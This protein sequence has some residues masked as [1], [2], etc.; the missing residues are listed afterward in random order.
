MKRIMAAAACILMGMLG[1]YLMNSNVP[2]RAWAGI[3][4][5]LP[6]LWQNNTTADATQV[7]QNFNQLAGC[8]NNVATVSQVTCGP[9]LDGGIITGTGTCSLSSARR[10]NPTVQTILGSSGTYTT[11]LNA[12]WPG[13][14]GALAPT[15]GVAPTAGQNGGASTF[16]RDCMRMAMVNKSLDLLQCRSAALKSYAAL[17]LALISLSW[18]M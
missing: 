17:A 1:A 5:T 16:G 12:L 3:T 15:L 13:A 9:G 8:F 11:P 4:C 2:E 6:V 18:E 7:M 10:T 14:A